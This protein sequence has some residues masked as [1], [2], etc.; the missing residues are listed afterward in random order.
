[1]TCVLG[2]PLSRA[3]ALLQ[4]EGL[5]V[6]CV[7]VRSRK[8][9]AGGAERVAHRRVHPVVA[10]R[11]PVAGLSRDLRDAAHEGAADPQNV[12]VHDD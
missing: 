3:V 12:N 5:T 1:M 2:Y 10:P 11:H 8:G 7:E 4:A 9:L 6:E